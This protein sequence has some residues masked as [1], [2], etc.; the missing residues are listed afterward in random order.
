MQRACVH[1]A[2][3]E[4]DVAQDHLLPLLLHARLHHREDG[5]GDLVQVGRDVRE[6]DLIVF[7]LA[8]LEHFVDEREQVVCGHEHLFLVV[9]HELG[10]A[11]VGA[12]DLE[13]ADD[14]V[15]G[16]ADIVAHTAQ[17]A[18]LGGVGTV[19]CLF[20]LEQG[21]HALLLFA[22]EV[23]GIAQADNDTFRPACG[24]GLDDVDLYR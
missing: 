22:L 24:Y 11:G 4:I 9:A 5:R 13:Q 7:E 16:R 2:H 3:G 21:L 1:I 18:R 15:E 14:A 19:G 23:V 12:V 8:H 20:G 10:V 17:E 6:L